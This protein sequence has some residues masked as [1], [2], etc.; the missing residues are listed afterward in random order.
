[1]DLK[2][3]ISQPVRLKWSSSKVLKDASPASGEAIS[4]SNCMKQL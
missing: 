4:G 3:K 1:M 2:L